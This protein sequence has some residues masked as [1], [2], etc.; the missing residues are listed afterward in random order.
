MTYSSGN[1]E[2]SFPTQDNS[3]IIIPKRNFL[4]ISRSNKE[5]NR[6][7]VQQNLKGVIYR[8]EQGNPTFF[9]D[10]ESGIFFI[11][12]D[13]DESL[14][15]ISFKGSNGSLN[16]SFSEERGLELSLNNKNIE[17]SFL[18]EIDNFKVD[19]GVITINGKN[20]AYIT[21]DI[22]NNFTF[23]FK[24]NGQLWKSTEANKIKIFDEN[25]QV[26]KQ[27]EI[28]KDSDDT[29]TNFFYNN[30][31]KLTYKDL[32][33]GSFSHQF[34][35]SG[36]DFLG[37][38]CELREIICEQ[39]K[40]RK[41][42]L[43]GKLEASEDFENNRSTQV[44]PG[45]KTGQKVTKQ[46]NGTD[47]LRKIERISIEEDDVLK[48]KQ[49]FDNKQREICHITYTGD[50]DKSGKPTIR[51][52]IETTYDQDGKPTVKESNI[53]RNGSTK[54]KTKALPYLNTEKVP[55]EPHAF[56]M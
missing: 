3:E 1:T 34:I 18:D 28:N 27:V 2:V 42:Y 39:G 44:L 4:G 12:S 24:P 6:F 10:E 31:G 8:D 55:S 41:E 43:N 29:I 53:L 19:H 22:E 17:I 48:S 47:S 33:R 49:F 11:N 5:L 51:N 32:T 40:Y 20:N 52:I 9:L 46:Y 7:N 15:D 30:K 37:I 50:L 45:T 38:T 36:I 13:I 23:E 35:Y 54:L 21:V 26:K 16:I 14:K 25:K 56:K